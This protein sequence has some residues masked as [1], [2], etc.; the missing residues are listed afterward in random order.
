MSLVLTLFVSASG[1]AQ[2]TLDDCYAKAK[3]NYPLIRQY[4]LLK[5]SERYSLSNIAKNYL[6]R[7]TLTGQATYQSDV[8][9]LPIDL[10]SLGIP[11]EIPEVGKDQYKASIDVSQ[12][13]W[14]GGQTAA[15]RHIVIA[16]SEVEKRG[17][18][19]S[20]YAI[21]QQVCQLFLGILALD[22]R[23]KN[24]DLKEADI[25][26]NKKWVE[27]QQKNDM[28]TQSELDQINLALLQLEQ[29]RVEQTAMKSAFC[30]MLS[31][32]I[33]E[34]VTD[35]AVLVKPSSNL[36]SDANIARPELALFDAQTSL[37]EMQN[38]A[39]TAKN[40]PNLGLFIQGGYGRPGLNML[41]DEF[42]FSAIG[43]LR[44][45]WNFGN[46]YT[47]KN[48]RRILQTNISSIA[49][50]RETFLFGTSLQITQEQ[51]DIEKV[52]KLLLKDD[53]IIRLRERV[54][55][56][57]ES[58][59]KNGVYLLNELIRDIN[60]EEEA[61]QTK[62]MHEIEL[63]LNIHNYKHTTGGIKN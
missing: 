50:Q 46:L 62:A 13:V 2:L 41:K 37:L 45:T 14:D 22:A 15:Q 18:D 16:S 53:E 7:V 21:E 51:A 35:S 12:T 58:K 10:K 24:L 47:Q 60:A 25:I 33:H 52:R 9:T 54:K 6:P 36:S 43:G 34:E 38:K 11:F 3:A 26:S 5:Q 39:I 28:A 56:A 29:A 42:A 48:E 57:S 30:R 8:T 1:F 20:M 32:F 4:D 27:S 55:R 49:L 23:L 31:L 63:L 19:V 61:R 40:R 59:Y 17:T 44:L